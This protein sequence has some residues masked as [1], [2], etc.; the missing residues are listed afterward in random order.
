MTKYSWVKKKSKTNVTCTLCNV[1]LSF[2]NM[3]ESALKRHEEPNLKKPKKRLQEERT[4]INISL[5]VLHFRD[6]HPTS[7][8]ALPF[9]SSQYPSSSEPAGEAIQPTIDVYMVPHLVA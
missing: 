3:G 8:S 6:V 2:E 9:E 5:S 1:E 4:K 7:Q